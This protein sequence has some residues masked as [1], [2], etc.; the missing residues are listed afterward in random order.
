MGIYGRVEV[1]LYIFFNF[2]IDEGEWSASSS[3]PFTSIP[4]G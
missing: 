3:D 4:T 1:N 2:A